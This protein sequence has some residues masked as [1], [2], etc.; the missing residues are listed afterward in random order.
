MRRYELRIFKTDEIEPVTLYYD[1]E[2]KDQ[3]YDF[4]TNIS[5]GGFVMEDMDDDLA[6]FTPPKFIKRIEI[7]EIAQEE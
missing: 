4:C 7:R 6:V 1:C 5:K 3:V 2:Y